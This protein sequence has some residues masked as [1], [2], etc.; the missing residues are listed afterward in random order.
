LNIQTEKLKKKNKF[1]NTYVYCE[2]ILPEEEK[3]NA[4]DLYYEMWL[5][6]YEGCDGDIQKA[7]ETWGWQD[8]DGNSTWEDKYVKN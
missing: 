1:G 6:T 8:M 4:I 2:H 7:K 3:Q 5:W